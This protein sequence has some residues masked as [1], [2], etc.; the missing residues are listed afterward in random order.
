[1]LSHFQKPWVLLLVITS[2][3]LAMA[4][5]VYTEIASTGINNQDLQLVEA[6]YSQDS[7]ESELL[8]TNEE[9]K[10]FTQTLPETV[11]IDSYFSSPINNPF[12]R[13]IKKPFGLMITPETSPVEGDRFSGTH[14]GVDFEMLEGELNDDIQVFVIC[15]GSLRIKTFANGYGGVAV[16]TCLVEG[17]EVSVIYG[18]LRLESIK[19]AVGD[20]LVQGQY[21]GLLGDDHSE[22]T[23]G[24]RKH[25]HLGIRKGVSNDIRGYIKTD[26]QL[27]DWY[28]ILEYLKK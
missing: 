21:L 22:E 27:T 3:M 5:F 19:V 9:D 12:K 13:V 25:L 28:D 26:D 24:V 11:S 4:I 16:Q 18:H 8:F 2:A 17:E 23:D 20:Q 6:S 15:N 1:M 14:V 7:R 10:P